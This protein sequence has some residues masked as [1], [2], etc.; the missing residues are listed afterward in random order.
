L[1]QAAAGHGDRGEPVRRRVSVGG[2]EVGAA[3]SE[4]EI[5]FEGKALTYTYAKADN[6][7][8]ALVSVDGVDRGA[9]DLYSSKNEWQSHT[10][11]CCFAAGRHVAVIRVAGRAD[12][13]SK[14]KFIDLYSFTV[15]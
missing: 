5:E 15:E 9:V 4:V 13:R 1:R 6:R 3:G 10:G 12:P 8:I 11:F 2:G 7:G 14:G